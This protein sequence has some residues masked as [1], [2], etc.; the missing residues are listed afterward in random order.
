MT[1]EWRRPKGLDNKIRRKVKGWPSSPNSG[2]RGPKISRGLHPSAFKEVRVF[3]VDNLSKVDPNLEAIRI[4]HTV[5]ARKRIEIV[6]RA[7]EM[8]IH[9]LNPK[10][11]KELEGTIPEKEEQ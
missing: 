2:Y 9:I 4:A 8:G 7:K 6:S 3:N 5:G 10:E 1:E 11:F